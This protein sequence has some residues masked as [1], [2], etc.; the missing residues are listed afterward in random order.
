VTDASGAPLIAVGE[1]LGP[2]GVR[3][4]VR[5]RPLTDRPRERF[6]AL[7]SCFL[8]EPAEN[9]KEPCRIVSRRFE[10][11]SVLLRLDGVDSP[12]AA[13]AL[14]GR[15]LAVE[16]ERALPPRPGEFYPWQLEGALV[17]TPDGR[18]LGRFLRVMDS[19]AQPLW[20]I[21]RDGHEW[22]LPAVPE[23]VVDVS[24]AERRIVASPPEGLEAL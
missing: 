23:F 1:V 6:D 5:V 15:L 13:R 19:P 3:G 21:E 9:R 22:L 16:R 14:A 18:P 17:E 8:W 12:E 20:V 11:T 10:A 2:H 24:V 7:E 4:D